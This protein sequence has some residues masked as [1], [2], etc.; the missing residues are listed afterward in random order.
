MSCATCHVYVAAEW[1]AKLKPR[2]EFETM[3]VEDTDAFDDAASRLSCQIE[4][5][6]E[7]DGLAITIAP[8]D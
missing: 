4:L 8:E 3:L 7:L 6:P 1:R 2:Q 5:K